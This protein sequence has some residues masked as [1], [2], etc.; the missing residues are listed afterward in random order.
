MALDD[1]K[2]TGYLNIL[3]VFASIAVIM[4]HVFSPIN[5]SFSTALTETESYYCVVLQN[6]WQ[7]CVPLFVMI[8]GVLFLNPHKEIS[9]DKLLK[10][11]FLRIVLVLFLFGIP[12]AFLELFFDAH[13][14]FSVE[15]LGKALVN[16]VQGKLWDHMWYLY[17]IGG[18]YLVMPVFKIFAEHAGRETIRYILIILFIF[19]SL[20]PLVKTIFSCTF[21]M[22]LPISSVYAF[23]LLLGHYVHRYNI[24]VKNTVLMSTVMLYLLYAILMPLIDTR[25]VNLKGGGALSFLG[26]DSPLVVMIT[27]GLFCL[28]RQNSKTNRLFDSLTPLCF[29]IYLIH[30]LFINFLYKFVKFTPQHY[31]LVLVIIGT[32]SITIVLSIAFSFCAR[33]IGVIKN[34]CQQVKP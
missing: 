3:R 29:G 10:R 25:F 7:W 5:S 2:D 28:I 4:I 6:L 30:T 8:S 18:L 13:Y 33:K 20:I 27:F 11:Y 19:T 9:V 16:V 24:T 22:Y 23:Y 1:I 15:Q 17:M 34:Q 26:Y 14:H 12:Y 21:G 31:P 32:M